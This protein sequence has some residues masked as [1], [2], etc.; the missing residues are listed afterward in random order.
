MIFIEKYFNDINKHSFIIIDI[1][2]NFAY[3]KKHL[4]N[5][6]N[7]PFPKLIIEPEKYLNK[8]DKF[9]LVCEYGIKSKKTCDILNK[10][11]YKTYNLK[12]GIIKIK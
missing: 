6:I 12:G 8:I 2:D 7:I 3:K 11:G 4:N 9:L 10:Q 1:R 5:S